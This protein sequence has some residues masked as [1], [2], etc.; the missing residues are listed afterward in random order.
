LPG[1][2]VFIVFGAVPLVIASVK[3][4]LGSTRYGAAAG[5]GLPGG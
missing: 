1:D 2:L 3:G 5:A 4:Y